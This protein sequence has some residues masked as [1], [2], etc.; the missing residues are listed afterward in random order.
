MV[1]WLPHRD[2]V[3]VTVFVLCFPSKLCI[4]SVNL[5][6]YSFCACANLLSSGC[7]MLFCQC[8]AILQGCYFFP[9]CCLHANWEE[10]FWGSMHLQ[11]VRVPLGLVY[12]QPFECYSSTNT[13]VICKH[14]VQE[15]YRIVAVFNNN[16]KE[17]FQ[18]C[19]S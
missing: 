4:F 11:V 16:S 5:H 3:W 2:L 9:L 15:T 12:T 14:T 1:C 18:L 7:I 17:Y 8:L 10:A 13:K 6:L 19:Q